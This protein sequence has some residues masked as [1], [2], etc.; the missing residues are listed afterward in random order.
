MPEK[1]AQDKS[2]AICPE[3]DTEVTIT[4][5][6]GELTGK[7]EKCGLDVGRVLTKRRYDRAVKKMDDAEAEDAK[8]G[9]KKESPWW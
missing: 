1:A 2:K 5:E 6:E 7:C 8:K 9:K 3:C 4:K